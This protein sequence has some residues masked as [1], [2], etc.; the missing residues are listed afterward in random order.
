MLEHEVDLSTLAAA[1]EHLRSLAEPCN[2]GVDGGPSFELPL[3]L[4]PNRLPSSLDE[5]EAEP[6][7]CDLVF[8]PDLE[9]VPRHD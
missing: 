2:R 6:G 1:P 9:A 8:T 5:L 3:R 4:D 7:C